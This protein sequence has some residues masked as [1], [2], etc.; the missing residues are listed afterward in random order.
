M[1]TH[2]YYWLTSPV[3]MVENLQTWNVNVIIPPRFVLSNEH[4][5][6]LL[7]Y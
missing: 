6:L 4:T 5:Y 3:V 7:A 1:N 2:T